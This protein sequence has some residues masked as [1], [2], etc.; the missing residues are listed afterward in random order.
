MRG[1]YGADRIPGLPLLGSR[2][3]LEQGG[4]QAPSLRPAPRSAYLEDFLFLSHSV[5]KAVPGG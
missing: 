2:T 3:E 1:V 5:L 4:T